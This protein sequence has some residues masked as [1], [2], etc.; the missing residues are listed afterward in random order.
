MA[1]KAPDY[2]DRPTVIVGV[3]NDYSSPAVSLTGFPDDIMDMVRVV[4]RD[5]DAG[6]EPDED[7]DMYEDEEVR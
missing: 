7:G 3:A 1:K 6:S 5:W 2:S 4:I